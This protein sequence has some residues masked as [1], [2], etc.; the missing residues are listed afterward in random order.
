MHCNLRPP[1]VVPVVL[2]F[3]YDTHNAPVYKLN[4]SVRDVS[5]IG[6]HLSVFI[7]QNVLR[8]RRNIV[9]LPVKSLTPLLDSATPISYVVRTFW[10]LMGI[11]HVTLTTEL[12]TL[13]T[14]S[15]WAVT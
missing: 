4:N 8:L 1:D 7:S 3:N 10:R 12:F 11:C 13:N 5:V 9:E 2:C 14:Y 6:E 15:I